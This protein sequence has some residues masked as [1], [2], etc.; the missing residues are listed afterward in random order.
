[1][2]CDDG[3]ER[4]GHHIA[5][6]IGGRMGRQLLRCAYRGFPTRRRSSTRRVLMLEV[7]TLLTLGGS[8]HRVRLSYVL[9]DDD[10]CR[11]GL[12]VRRLLSEAPLSSDGDMLPIL[13]RPGVHV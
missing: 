11:K 12:T 10:G 6:T 2:G 9:E 7:D 13:Q 8:G 1:M 4:R 5:A 3:V